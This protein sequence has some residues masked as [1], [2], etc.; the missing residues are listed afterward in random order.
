MRPADWP[1]ARD[2]ETKVQSQSWR[3]PY[4]AKLSLRESIAGRPAGAEFKRAASLQVGFPSSVAGK[5]HVVHAGG[6]RIHRQ[7]PALAKDPARPPDF[8]AI[9]IPDG[10]ENRLGKHRVSGEKAVENGPRQPEKPT[11]EQL[12]HEAPCSRRSFHAGRLISA[13]VHGR[14]VGAMWLLCQKRIARSGH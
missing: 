11:V 9:L 14:R 13:G 8:K 12:P 5:V 6:L 3:L 2:N 7:Y 1:D 10:V 4:R